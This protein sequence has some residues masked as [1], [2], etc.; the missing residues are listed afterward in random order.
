[1]SDVFTRE[2]LRI[3]SEVL[4]DVESAIRDCD[5]TTINAVPAR[6]GVPASGVNSVFALVTHIDGMV[7][8]W[9]GSV[10]SGLD[11]PRDR[12]AE[13][14]ATGTVAEALALLDQT[15]GRVLAWMPRALEDGI[16]NPGATGSTRTDIASATPQFVVLHVLRELAQH[17]G[18]LQICRDLV[19]P[20]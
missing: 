11:I 14:V 13:F 2:Y 18:H 10:V 17:A 12:A 6:G 7:G 4:D 19:V 1:M 3:A 20:D 5:D 16:A 8:F 15:R 9:L